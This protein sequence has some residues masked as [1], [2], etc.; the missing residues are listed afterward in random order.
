MTEARVGRLLAACLHQAI[1]DVLPQRLDFYEEWLNPDGLRDGNIGLAPLTAVIGF[2]RTEGQDYGRVVARAGT[3]AAEWT[4]LSLPSVTRRIQTSLPRPFRTRAA[5]RVAATIIRDVLSTT[6]V[7]ARVRRDRVRLDVRSSLFCTVRERQALP[8][9]GFYAAVAVETLKR[10]N[11]ASRAAIEEC[12]AVSGGSCVLTLK[13]VDAGQ[14]I[15]PA[16]AA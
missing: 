16:L 1:S 2:L 6:A 5:T 11:L 12:R 13:L 4:V 3:L 10:F 9:C 15:D 14:A 7:K 8:L